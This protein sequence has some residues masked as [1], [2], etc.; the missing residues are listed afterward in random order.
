VYKI[1]ALELRCEREGVCL[2]L[3]WETGAGRLFQ[4]L[5]VNRVQEKY[6]TKRTIGS[7]Q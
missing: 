7:Q 6:S 4:F 1:E 2:W 5:S 3:W